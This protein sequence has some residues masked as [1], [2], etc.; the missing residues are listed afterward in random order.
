[1]GA[2]GLRQA[3]TVDR[4]NAAVCPPGQSQVRLWDAAQPGL[5]VRVYSSGSKTYWA[6]YR[7]NG[8]LQWYKIGSVDAVSL[9]DA[10][11]AARIKLGEVAKGGDPAGERREERRRERAHLEPALDAYE[12]SLEER[13]VVKRSEYLSLLRRELL[14]PLGNVDL[15]AIRLE[16]I[17]KRVNALKPKRPGTAKELRTRA[18]V[19]LSW[20]AAEGLIK[21]SPLAGYRQPRR[22]RAQRLAEEQT[23]D[24]ARALADHEI[25]ILWKAADAEGWPFGP[26]LQTL[27]LTGQ[28]R[29]ETAKMCW[30]DVDLEVGMWTIPAA[31]TKSG[32]QHHVPL[33][34]ALVSILSALPRRRGSPYVFPGRKGTALSGFSKRLL[35]IYKVTKGEGSAHWTLHDLR[36]TMRSGLTALGVEDDVAEMMLNHQIGDELRRVYDK[37]GYPQARKEAAAAWSEHVIGLLT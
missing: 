23:K 4:V 2:K 5:L 11:D 1:M 26:Y 13:S 25:P 6:R 3:L 19:F 34:P 28:R 8:K 9:K 17:V 29:T 18:G 21:L 20:C 33:P 12:R 36:R 15:D 31:D 16:T 24:E 10:R 22:T 7:R 14:G 32:R 37:F 35:P 27:L 30:S